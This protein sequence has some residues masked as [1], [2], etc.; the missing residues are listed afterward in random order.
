MGVRTITEEIA[1]PPKAD[2][3]DKCFGWMDNPE[4]RKLL[5]VVS[6]IIAAEYIEVAKRNKDVFLNGGGK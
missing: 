1:S 2:R 6:E 5:D 3:N 4:I